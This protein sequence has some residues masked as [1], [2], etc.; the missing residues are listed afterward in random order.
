MVICIEAFRRDAEKDPRDAGAT[1]F[2]TTPL[3]QSDA[4]FS[5]AAE[6][7]EGAFGGFAEEQIFCVGD[8]GAPEVFG[9]GVF[10]VDAGREFDAEFAE[11]V[12]DERGAIHGAFAR[13]EICSGAQFLSAQGE[14]G[15]EKF[16]HGI[17]GAGGDEFETFAEERGDVFFGQSEIED[18]EVRVEFFVVVFG[19]AIFLDAELDVFVV[20]LEVGF[21]D[22]MVAVGAR[23]LKNKSVRPE[24]PAFLGVEVAFGA[25]DGFVD[26]GQSTGE[27]DAARARVEFQ[28]FLV[29]EVG[30]ADGFVLGGCGHLR[31]CSENRGFESKV[32]GPKSK[33]RADRLA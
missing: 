17:F 19:D 32:Q 27:S 20:D 1:L 10:A 7:F 33:V 24:A 22:P 21:D 15:A 16:A 18:G 4:G 11:D 2:Y 25:A 31:G 9:S 8:G 28:E 30:E 3:Q 12:L 23:A 14:Q 6:F 13:E 29:G 26:E 5:A